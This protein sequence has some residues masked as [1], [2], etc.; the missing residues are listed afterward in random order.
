MV[1]SR[2][3]LRLGAAVAATLAATAGCVADKDIV[4]TE[5]PPGPGVPFGQF[6]LVAFDTCEEAEA[7][8]RAAARRYVGPWGFGQAAPLP[9]MPIEDAGAARDVAGA[10]AMAA[11]EAADT[12]TPRSSGTNTHEVG[13][14]EPDLVKTDGSR[15]VTVHQGVLRVVDARRGV[16]TGSLDL[17]GE[18]YWEFADL[19]LYGDHALVLAQGDAH[20]IR[21]APRE[22][23]VD[24]PAP[25]LGRPRLVLVDLSGEPRVLSE[26]AIDGALVDARLTGPAARVVVRSFPR[27][28]F[29]DLG[30]DATD[31]QRLE[32]NRRAVDEADLSDWLPRYRVTTGDRVSEGQVDCAA[33]HRPPTYTG[34]SMLTLL[35]FDLTAAELG[36]GDP[37]SVVADGD[38]VYGTGESLYVTSDRRWWLSPTEEIDD[39]PEVDDRTEVYK[40]DLS[41]AGPPRYVASGTVDGW[42]VNQYA[43]SEWDGHLRVATTAGQAWGDGRSST[44]SSVTVLAQ[45]GDRL[46]PVGSV[47]GLGRGEQIYSVRFAGP[48][49]YVVTFR[50]TDPLY[51]LDLSDPTAPAVRGELKITG[52]SSYLHPIGDDRLIGVGQEADTD[53]RVLGAQVSLFDVSDLTDPVRLAQ[54]HVR[55]GYS[56]V[57]YDPHAFLWWP[58]E[59]LLVLPL[60]SYDGVGQ[61]AG[62]LVL[63][64]DDRAFTELALVTHPTSDEWGGSPP[65]RRSLV[66]GD[67]LWT[68]SG[69]G[70]QA[71]DL[72]TLDQIAWLPFE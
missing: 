72:S 17:G 30:P 13:A 12:A 11:P 25:R 6:R 65:I 43:M 23:V 4:D 18:G 44:E 26:Y 54:H 45:Q 22:P 2:T 1:A 24:L 55:A 29:P 56:E 52:Y 61:E 67:V 5:P 47:G 32:A 15:I 39:R 3:L 42:L 35:T 49:A 63:R 33:V 16:Q 34:A 14:D 68:V 58:A 59:R 71:N 66:V 48:I 38:T 8:L 7:S 53:G 41:Q 31:E 57:E 62:A 28:E 27:L 36:D 60:T 46:V 69:A 20:D 50:Q 64:V 37:V 21:I 9:A 40:F 51:T 19:L 70:L 10:R